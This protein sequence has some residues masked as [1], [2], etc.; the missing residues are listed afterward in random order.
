MIDGM[1]RSWVFLCKEESSGGDTWI[2]V[3]A[4]REGM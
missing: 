2:V 1:P 3:E 4:M